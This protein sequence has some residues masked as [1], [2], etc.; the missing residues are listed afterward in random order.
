MTTIRARP[1]NGEML[2]L[3][4]SDSDLADLWTVRDLKKRLAAADPSSPCPL[5]ASLQLLSSSCATPQIRYAKP[6]IDIM[7]RIMCIYTHIYI[8]VILYIYIHMS[9]ILI[10]TCIY[11]YNNIMIIKIVIINIPTFLQSRNLRSPGTRLVR[12]VGQNGDLQD[13]EPSLGFRV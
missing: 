6:K 4:L 5:T 13:D 8:Y 7:Y 9:H 12:L 10:F 1:L 3:Q 11:I 2:E